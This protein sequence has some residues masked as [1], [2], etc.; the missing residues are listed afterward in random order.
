M[1]CAR[2]VSYLLY[3]IRLTTLTVFR[4]VMIRDINGTPGSSDVIYYN[5]LN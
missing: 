5:T 4:A 2:F 1:Q 3:R